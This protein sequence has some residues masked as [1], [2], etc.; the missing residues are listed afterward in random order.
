MRFQRSFVVTSASTALGSEATGCPAANSRVGTDA[1]G[2]E[3]VD[4][5]NELPGAVVYDVVDWHTPILNIHVSDAMF[6]HQTSQNLVEAIKGGLVITFRQKQSDRCVL[7]T[8]ASAPSLQ[9][10]R[11]QL[12]DFQLHNL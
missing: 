10:V 11:F 2:Q 1:V 6:V 3:V 9:Q 8:H 7:D 12:L 5:G 4:F